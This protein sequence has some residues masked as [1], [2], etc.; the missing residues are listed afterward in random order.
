[1]RHQFRSIRRGAVAGLALLS[2]GLGAAHLPA[3]PLAWQPLTTGSKERLRGVSAVI[4]RTAW[5]SG[6]RGTVLRTVDGGTTWTRLVV[7]EAGA[8]DFRDIEAV[9]ANVASVLSIGAGDRSRI[10]KTT[11]GGVM[12]SEQFR[13]PDSRA[14]FDDIAFWNR[15]AGLAM[16]DPVDGHFTVI[17]TNDGGRTWTPVAPAAMPPALEGEGAFAAGGNCLTVQGPRNAWFASGG[18]ARARVFRSTDQ[19]ATWQVAGTP[20]SAGASSA[21][22]FSIAFSDARHGIV[23]G[24]DYRK[25]QEPGDNVAWTEDGGRTWTLGAARLRGFRSGVAFVP[26]TGGRAALAVGPAGSDL[27]IDKGASWTPIEGAGYD[28]VRIAGRTAWASGA[29]GRVGRLTVPR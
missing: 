6:S 1:M 27:S 22:I 23:V 3:P 18:G 17:R 14:F 8:L 28:A 25:E 26:G 21:G 11:D 9:D 15:D 20:V 5:A 4:D 19:G 12:W 13:N 10:F 24:G 2:L 29:G 7:P 16:G